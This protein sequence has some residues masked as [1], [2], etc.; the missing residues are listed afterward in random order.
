M[1]EQEQKQRHMALVSDNATFQAGIMA[2][3]VAD[4]LAEGDVQGAQAALPAY[5]TAAAT[6]QNKG[7][8]LA[9]EL[10]SADEAP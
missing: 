7:A 4:K 10:L 8:E 3:V 2:M 9:A 1:D 5:L 6:A